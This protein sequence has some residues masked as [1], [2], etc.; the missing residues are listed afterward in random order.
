[1]LINKII[2]K[3]KY[4][5]WFC[6]RYIKYFIWYFIFLLLKT[7]FLIRITLEDVEATAQF[8]SFLT[9]KKMIIEFKNTPKI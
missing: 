9:W 3:I 4:I 6:F 2:I 5:G 7:T 8:L 1:M